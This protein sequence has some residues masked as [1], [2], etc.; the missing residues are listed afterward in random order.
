M[1]RFDEHVTVNFGDG[2]HDTHILDLRSIPD[3]RQKLIEF[4][5][6]HI[7]N[8]DEASDMRGAFRKSKRVIIE[9]K[10]RQDLAFMKSLIHTDEK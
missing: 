4:L 1:D 6:M 3:F 9:F 10:P 7:D 8:P 2:P 5:N